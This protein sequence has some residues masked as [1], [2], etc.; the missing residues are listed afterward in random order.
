MGYTSWFK[1]AEYIYNEIKN[2]NIKT[3][4]VLESILAKDWDTSVARS[5]D[6]RLNIENDWI[7]TEGMIIPVW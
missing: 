5:N 6:T 1:V 3:T 4:S 7:K 2:H